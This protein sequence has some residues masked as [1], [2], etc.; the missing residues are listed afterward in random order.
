[1]AANAQQPVKPQPAGVSGQLIALESV[2]DRMADRSAGPPAGRVPDM[3]GPEVLSFEEAARAYLAAAGKRRPLLP[4]P[5]PGKAY[6]GFKRGGHLAPSHA[7]GRGTFAEFLTA[8][9]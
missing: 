3:G 9:R 5:L 7:V 8:R 1:L 4:V 2:A 6:A